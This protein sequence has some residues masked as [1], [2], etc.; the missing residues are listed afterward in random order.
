MLCQ[1]IKREQWVD[2]LK[3]KLLKVPYSHMVFT[4]PHQFNGL[5]RRNEKVIYGLM[6]R[7]SWLTVS[8]IMKGTKVGM[9]SVL[10]TF[11]SD[12]KYHIHV[13]S[14]VTFG[15]LDTNGDWQYPSCKYA[16][17]KYRLLCS[18]FKSIFIQELQ[19]EI[20]KDKVYYHQ[21]IQTVI[22]ESEKIRWVVHSTYPTMQTQT[23][24]NYLAKYINRVGVTNNRLS[25]LK[26]KQIVQLQYNDYKNQELN[27]AAPKAYKN[28]DP[29]VAMNQILQ[30]VLPPYF[31]KSRHHGLH[32]A[33][34]K[35][36]ASIPDKLL[37]NVVS[38]R[39]V[40]EILSHLLNLKPFTCDQCQSTA[41]D[42]KEISPVRP[43]N[44]KILVQPS[45]RAPPFQNLIP[46]S[47]NTSECQFSTEVLM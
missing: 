46:R 26:E 7:V 13:H 1:S 37:K 33:N 35:T 30:H 29:L 4:L 27:K 3:T 20:Q 9:T 5:A 21:D 40:F 11:G 6:M 23:I 24:E 45:S 38:I 43:I 12:M 2:K 25:Y 19:K 42:I 16:L 32:S 15:G 18:S 22:K 17:A 14:L 41:F 47:K 34:E 8:A 28:L 10:H 31:Q 36:K 39:T 44:N